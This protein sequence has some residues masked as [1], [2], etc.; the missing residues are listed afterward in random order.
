MVH[1]DNP[2]A[3]CSRCVVRGVFRWPGPHRDEAHDGTLLT[4]THQRT[5]ATLRENSFL[6][7]AGH[8]EPPLI[9]PLRSLGPL[10]PKGVSDT[11]TTSD[12]PSE[13][14]QKPVLRP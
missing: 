8:V 6:F 1:C 4:G 5:A 11:A 7:F 14:Q 3:P 12:D 13:E 2:P 9:G 10:K